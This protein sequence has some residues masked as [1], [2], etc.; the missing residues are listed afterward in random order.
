MHYQIYLFRSTQSTENELVTF[1]FCDVV[2]DDDDD[3]DGSMSVQMI[4]DHSI[5]IQSYWTRSILVFV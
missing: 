3:D 2:D 5:A 1:F 4:D